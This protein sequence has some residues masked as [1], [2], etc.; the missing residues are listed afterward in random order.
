[1]S[2]GGSNKMG[3]RC[4]RIIYWDVAY[5]NDSRQGLRTQQIKNKG[6]TK[7]STGGTAATAAT[8]TIYQALAVVACANSIKSP[9]ERPQRPP[10]PADAFNGFLGLPVTQKSGMRHWRRSQRPI[11]GRELAPSRLQPP[12]EGTDGIRPAAGS[13]TTPRGCRRDHACAGGVVQRGMKDCGGGR[14]GRPIRWHRTPIPALHS[15]PY[16]R[17]RVGRN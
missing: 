5:G 2:I 17:H 6:R 11:W 9:P 16:G 1:V 14:A 8:A 15:C 12:T 13:P 4:Q 10:V 3:V 7:A